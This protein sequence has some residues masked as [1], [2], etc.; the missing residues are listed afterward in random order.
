[1]YNRIFQIKIILYSIE[2]S[3]ELGYQT[4][5]GHVSD[6]QIRAEG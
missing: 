1:M 4:H 3:R 6:I 2:N 5:T